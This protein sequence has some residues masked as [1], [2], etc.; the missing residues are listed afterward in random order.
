MAI[1][2]PFLLALLGAALLGA[3]FFAVQNARND[4]ADDAAPVAQQAV[5]EQQ[6]APQQAPAANPREILQSAFKG[7][8]LDSTAFTAT[9]SASAAGERLS[10]DLS[11]A[12][13]QGAA[14]DV[15]EFE[16]S[17]KLN[18]DG[19]RMEGGF[20]SLGDEAYFTRG[21]DG[22]R[23]PDEVWSPLVEAVASAPAAQPQNLA[24]P[25]DPQAWVRDVK[26]EGTETLDGV[27]TTHVSASLEPKRVVRGMLAATRVTGQELPDRIGGAVKS[28]ELDAWVGT[29]DRVVRRLAVDVKSAGNSELSLQLEL[30]GVNEPQDIEAPARVRQGMPGGTFGEFAQGFVTGLSGVTGGDSVS[31]AALTSP[32]PRKAARAVADGKKVVIYFRNPDGLDDRVMTRVVRELDRRTKAVVLSDHVD[33]VDRYGK[34]VEEL[35]VSQTPAVVLIDRTGEARLIEGYVDTDTLAQA[36]ADAR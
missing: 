14:N 30:T 32:N 20:V 17:A 22:W 11:G 25:F 1:S 2:R 19:E 27:E 7:G 24:V 31:L 3:T 29:D 18:A 13:E 9:V 5:P 10:F 33:A 28:A 36:V 16:V 6:A 23:V 21:R 12:F 8:Q 26:S 35:G 4:S 34:M 15:P